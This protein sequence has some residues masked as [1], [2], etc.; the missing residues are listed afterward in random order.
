MLNGDITTAFIKNTAKLNDTKT[1]SASATVGKEFAT[2]IA[3][4]KFEP[5]IQLIYQQLSFDTLSDAANLGIDI[6][7]PPQWMA[8]IGKRLRKIISTENNRSLFFFSANL[9]TASFKRRVVLLGTLFTRLYFVGRPSCSRMK[10]KRI[11]RDE[12]QIKQINK[13]I[14]VFLKKIEQ[15]MKQILTQAT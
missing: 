12:T 9:M 15:D 14:E 7:D 3:G 8:R 2:G 4:I 10:I 13:A 6:K 11:G 5:Q 1:F